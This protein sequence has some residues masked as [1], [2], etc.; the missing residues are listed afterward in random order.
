MRAADKYYLKARDYYPYDYDEALEALEYGLSCDDEH[1]GLLV[2]KARIYYTDLKRFDAAKE[3][4]ELALYYDAAFIDTYYAYLDFALTT[5]DYQLMAKLVAKAMKQKGI[6]KAAVLYKEAL[7]HEM[8][9]NYD[10]AVKSLANA[11]MYCT[12][13][14]SLT[15]Y[16]EEAERVQEK[17]RTM[18]ARQLPINIILK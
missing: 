9:G 16:E 12:S 18:R 5:E 7:M 11:R 8:C 6:D 14:K 10:S 3:C 13:G 1:A 17:E 4:F 2:L 15:F